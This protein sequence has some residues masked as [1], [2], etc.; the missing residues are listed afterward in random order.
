M[1]RM[2][3]ARSEKIGGYMIPTRRAGC[4]R[5]EFEYV[6]GDV[7]NRLGKYEDLGMEPEELKKELEMAER[8]RQLIK[9]WENEKK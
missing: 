4:L 6:H 8:Y 5:I 7:V 1:E 2:T 3:F 9:H